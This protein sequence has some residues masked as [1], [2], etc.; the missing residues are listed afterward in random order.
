MIVVG[1]SLFLQQLISRIVPTG[2]VDESLNTGSVAA[3]LLDG[4]SDPFAQKDPFE[5]FATNSNSGNITFVPAQAPP[6]VAT[7]EPSRSRMKIFE[8]LMSEKL[9]NAGCVALDVNFDDS[10]RATLEDAQLIFGSKFV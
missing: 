2:D 5:A 4:F 9:C 3:N 8:R 7:I 10:G 1:H 6:V